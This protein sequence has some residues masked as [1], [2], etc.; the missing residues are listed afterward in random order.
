MSY[1][2]IGKKLG[3]D[4]SKEEVLN[5]FRVVKEADSDAPN[6]EEEV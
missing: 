1:A 2:G 4:P 6:I 3:F 5:V